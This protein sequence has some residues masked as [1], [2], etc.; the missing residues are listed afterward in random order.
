MD[1]S[2]RSQILLERASRILE[3]TSMELADWEIGGGTVLAHYFQHRLSKDIDIFIDDVQKLSSIS[4]RFNDA[5]EDALDYDEMTNY[6][7][8]T[9]PEG[10]VDFIVGAQLSD[11]KSKKQDFLG[12][13]VYLEDPVEIVT[14]KLYY[15]GD[16]AMARDIFDLSVVI[17]MREKDLL[18]T[19]LRF[20]EKVNA[21]YKR[22]MEVAKANNYAL[23][24]P[25]KNSILPNGEQFKENAL[26]ICYEFCQDFNRKKKTANLAR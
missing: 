10:K 24:I 18:K 3:N 25:Q 14:K 1:N 6:I 5:A 15:R 8:L 12:K 16:R 23:Q 17:S 11:F 22:F 19:F 7:S 26:K 21:F 9:F 2:E 4:P 20:P 13:E